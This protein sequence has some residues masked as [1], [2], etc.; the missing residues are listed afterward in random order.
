MFES[1]ALGAFSHRKCGG[2]FGQPVFPKEVYYTLFAP[3]LGWNQSR[4]E[5]VREGAGRAAPAGSAA[6]FYFL[7]R[8]D[9]TDTSALWRRALSFVL[10]GSLSLK[11]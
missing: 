10:F 5:P 3:G 8:T 9:T 1:P 6:I 4:S 7:V 2:C 11:A